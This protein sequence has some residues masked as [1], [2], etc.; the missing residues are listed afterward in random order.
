MRV[1]IVVDR[2]DSGLGIAASARSYMD[3]SIQVIPALEYS[4]ADKFLRKLC[5]EN[6]ET[7][8]FSWRFL[9]EE[10]LSVKKSMILIDQIKKTSSLGIL[11][12]DHLGEEPI[13]QQR[14]DFLISKIDF[15]LVTS[16]ILYTR[17]MDSKHSYKCLGLLHDM[18]NLKHIRAMR[19]VSSE[20]EQRVVW[21]GNSKWGARQSNQSGMG[22]HRN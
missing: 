6:F 14:E 1:A 4:S 2:L 18:P 15:F 3:S 10:L 7:I 8:V 5:E 9:L 19:D 20:K 12:P 17:Y 21:V 11:I 13:N 16:R 22:A